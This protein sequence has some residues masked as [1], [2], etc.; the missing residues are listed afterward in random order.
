MIRIKKFGAA[1]QVQEDSDNQGGFKAKAILDD[2]GH[3]LKIT[4]EVN[5]NVLTTRQIE[6]AHKRIR[7]VLDSA[8]D[9][10]NGLRDYNP[11]MSDLDTLFE[12]QPD[13]T[14]IDM[15]DHA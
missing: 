8:L 13:A 14:V 9:T 7:N 5:Y 6:G 11:A 12:G 10:A 3:S 1:K 4:V 15:G 2:H